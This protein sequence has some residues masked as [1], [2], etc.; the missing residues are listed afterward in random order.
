MS[1]LLLDGKDAGRSSQRVSTR[2]AQRLLGLLA[3]SPAPLTVHR[4]ALFCNRFSKISVDGR[5]SVCNSS[6][7]EKGS[8]VIS[9]VNSITSTHCALPASTLA[10]KQP[11]E[12]DG[13][14]RVECKRP[15]AITGN[16]DLTVNAKGNLKLLR[17]QA[18]GANNL[19]DSPPETVVLLG[20]GLVV[21]P[22]H[23]TDIPVL[24]RQAQKNR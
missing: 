11:R 2:K 4:C 18:S 19:K 16:A 21:E 23:A 8:N 10:F 3:V 6:P 24:K 22:A 9:T 20:S 15:S 14:Y 1:S 17:P 5:T 12:V 7:D 13:V